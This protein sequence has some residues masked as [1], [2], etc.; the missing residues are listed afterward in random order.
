MKAGEWVTF[1]LGAGVNVRIQLLLLRGCS[2]VTMK[3]FSFLA[4]LSILVGAA[5]LSAS[6]AR[7]GTAPTGPVYEAIV[8]DAETGQ[9]L[10]ELNPDAVTYPAS[11]TKMM[12]LYLTFEAL[13][14]GRLRIDQ[15]LPI[16]PAAAAH[17]PSKLGLEPGEAVAVRDLIL[18]IVTK[19][20][21]DAAAVLAEGLGGGSEAAFAVMMT[22]KAQ[23]LGMTRTHYA[24]ASGLPD[25]E[26]L[27]TA[28]DLARLSLAL[29]HDFPREYRYFAVKQ[30]D[31]QGEIVNGH[32]HML[33]WYPGADGIKTGFTVASG[34]NLATS[35]VQNGR[36]LIGVILGGRTIRGRDEAM[37]QML[38]LGFGDLARQPGVMVA[39]RQSPAAPVVAA[40]APAAQE[41]PQAQPSLAAVAAASIAAPAA[42]QPQAVVRQQAS[43]G[44]ETAVSDPPPSRSATTL[45]SVASAA[46]SHLA[47]V[48]KAEAAPVARPAGEEWGIQLGAFRAEAAAERVEHE[49]SGYALA[50]GK[51]SQIL[52]PTSAERLYRAR[53][54]YFSAQGARAACGELRRQH[55]DCSLVPP[56]GLK[57]ASR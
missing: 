6:A 27:T 38:D 50:R 9:V 51:Q 35:A 44:S 40:V 31:F 19:S 30:F 21:N 42:A 48:A 18:G 29:Y 11:L 16:S 36:R 10:R 41:A 3:S 26:Q 57:V 39:Q 56:A 24:N 45:G 37:A 47:P 54:L 53:L 22:Q 52:A 28:R 23:Q 55:I 8:I 12:T 25:P 49:V 7:V 46:F 43:A 1:A 32:D 15:Y 34:Y 17:A 4:S 13:N 33:D 14:Q 5:P 2:R 20:A